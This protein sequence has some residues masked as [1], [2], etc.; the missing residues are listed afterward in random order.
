MH[1]FFCAVNTRYR[2]NTKG[3]TPLLVTEGVTLGKDKEA[4]KKCWREHFSD[5]LNQGSVIN[6]SIL[7]CIPQHT[8][9]HEVSKTSVL[10][11][12]EKAICQLKNNKAPGAD[13]IPVEAKSSCCSYLS[14]RRR[15]PRRDLR[16]HSRGLI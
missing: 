5:L 7:E 9:C 16:Y 6:P 1:S 12:V 14:G 8:T 3:P 15:H 2:P 11:E 13:G 10:H 4:I